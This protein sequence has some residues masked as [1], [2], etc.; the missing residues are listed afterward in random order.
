[1]LN[2]YDAEKH[3]HIVDVV[4]QD[5]KT[6]AYVYSSIATWILGYP[7]RALQ[8]ND[9]KDAHARRRGQPFDLGLALMKGAH[10]FDSRSSHKDLRKRAEE[11]E[12]LGRENSLPVLWTIVASTLHGQAFLREGKPAEAIAPLKA[13]IAALE[14]TGGKTGSP[15]QRACLAEAITLT[16]DFDNA[17]LLLDEAIAQIERPGWEERLYYAEVLRL[18]GWVLSLKGDLAGAERNFLASLDWARRQQAKSWEAAH[19]D[20]PRPPVAEPGPTPGG[21]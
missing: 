2:L 11:C 14:A 16:G 1:V 13:G 15:I 5:P 20:E 17:L 8:L 18:Q 19:G 12:R 10:E 6:L 7:D 4:Y 9:E 21:I 3:R